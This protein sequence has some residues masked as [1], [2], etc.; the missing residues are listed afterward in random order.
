MDDDIAQVEQRPLARVQAFAAQRAHALFLDLLQHAF[1][2]GLH[3]AT[4]STAGD[5]HEIGDAG[6][7]AHVDGG[8]VLTF[9]VFQGRDGDLDEFFVLHRVQLPQ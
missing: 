7:A 8:D 2:Q 6:L 9:Q 1:G 5:H 3:M 4:G